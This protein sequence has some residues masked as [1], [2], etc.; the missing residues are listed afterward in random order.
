[1]QEHFHERKHVP[2]QTG[3]IE[4]SLTN[5]N[6]SDSIQS[7][8]TLANSPPPELLNSNLGSVP[9][10]ANSSC[11]HL[12]ALLVLYRHPLACGKVQ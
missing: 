12:A 11:V 5:E 1:M 7:Q 2:L 6:A 4:D 3:Q 8:E 10:F 9:N